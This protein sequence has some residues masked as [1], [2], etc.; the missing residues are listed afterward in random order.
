MNF[1]AK[2]LIFWP[3]LK[4]TKSLWPISRQKFEPRNFLGLFWIQ[5]LFSNWIQKIKY[6]FFLKLIFFDKKWRLGT[7][8]YNKCGHVCCAFKKSKL[9]LFFWFINCSNP[10]VNL[11]ERNTCWC[12]MVCQKLFDGFFVEFL[13]NHDSFVVMLRHISNYFVKRQLLGSRRFATRGQKQFWFP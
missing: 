2:K 12:L 7:L 6:K 10:L 1:R 9:L 3:Q 8:W 11:A 13:L 5:N 4:V